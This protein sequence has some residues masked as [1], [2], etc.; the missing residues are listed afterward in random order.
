M[1]LI[2]LAGRVHNVQYTD[3]YNIVA[4]M[5]YTALWSVNEFS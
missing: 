1:K 2:N 5:L 3:R 4:V